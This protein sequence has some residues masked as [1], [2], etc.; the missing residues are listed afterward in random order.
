MGSRH[1]ILGFANTLIMEERLAFIVTFFVT[2]GIV[3]VTATGSSRRIWQSVSHRSC[4]TKHLSRAPQ[5]EE[6]KQAACKV[7]R[8][9]NLRNSS[10]N[11][12]DIGVSV[13]F[14]AFKSIKRRNSSSDKNTRYSDGI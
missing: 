3:V 6:I 13:I 2:A 14:L 10:L 5:I 7:I 8:V 1:L 9:Q 12:K 11:H 4:I